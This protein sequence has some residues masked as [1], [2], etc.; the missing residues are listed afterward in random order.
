MPIRF[1]KILVATQTD[2]ILPALR[3]LAGKLDRSSTA[4]W[5]A[6]TGYDFAV[7]PPISGVKG[8]RWF[9]D[10]FDADQMWLPFPR[11]MPV[12]LTAIYNNHSQPL[13]TGFS[14]CYHKNL[15][16]H[17]DCEQE[18]IFNVNQTAGPNRLIAIA[19]YKKVEVSTNPFRENNER[20]TTSP[21]PSGQ[22]PQS[23]PSDFQQQSSTE[24]SEVLRP[25]AIQH[26]IER[27]VGRAFNTLVYLHVDTGK[28]VCGSG[29]VIAEVRTAELDVA[30][31]TW[32]I[33]ID[34]SGTS[35]R[36]FIRVPNREISGWDRPC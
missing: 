19:A 20:S 2:E 26:A 35:Q 14:V 3:I 36:F 22:R 7:G 9:A 17:C 18:V 4:I 13:S 32:M 8:K 27:E 21:L 12:R 30:R 24:L 6:I 25:R 16:S 34:V 5:V 29:D 1:E 31:E 10:T 28:I 15:P 11:F 23:V 33:D